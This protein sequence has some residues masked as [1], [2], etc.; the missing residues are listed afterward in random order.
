MPDVT[1]LARNI[2]R[3]YR[4]S[5]WI[6]QWQGARWYVEA[7]RLAL[8]LSPGNVERGAGVIAALS[9]REIWTRNANNARLLFANGGTGTIGLGANV[10]KAMRIYAG[11]AP[12]DVLGGPKVRAFYGCIVDAG[13]GSDVCVDLHAWHVATG[14]VEAID[15]QGALARKGMYE[16][17]A[18]CYRRAAAIISREQGEHVSPAMV[19]ATTWLWQRREVHRGARQALRSA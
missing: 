19:Q 5:D 4:L 9:P 1:P 14:Q 10:A 11:E 2:T 7:N 16:R 13:W 15:S 18:S 17:T 6:D 3:A 8:E 12:L